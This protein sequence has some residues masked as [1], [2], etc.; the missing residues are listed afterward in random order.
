MLL[1][2]PRLR[3]ILS[4]QVIHYFGFFPSGR[5]PFLKSS[6]IVGQVEVGFSLWPSFLSPL[7]MMWKRVVASVLDADVGHLGDEMM[8]L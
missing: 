7:E 8:S 1:I 3:D 6:R 2:Q 4:V 5:C